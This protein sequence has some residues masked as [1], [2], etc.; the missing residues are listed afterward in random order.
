MKI[1]KQC[2]KYYIMS[3]KELQKRLGIEERIYS[4][5]SSLSDK[6]RIIV[7]VK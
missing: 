7:K 3:F 6:I 1:D 4:V 5:E 2:R